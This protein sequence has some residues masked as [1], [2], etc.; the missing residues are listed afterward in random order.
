MSPAKNCLEE[1]KVATE[2]ATILERPKNP[3]KLKRKIV[4]NTE[5]M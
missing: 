2:S 1:S 3:R 4:L 5:P